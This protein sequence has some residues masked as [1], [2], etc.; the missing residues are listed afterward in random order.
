MYLVIPEMISLS[1]KTTL[2]VQ[3]FTGLFL[4]IYKDKPRI[5]AFLNGSF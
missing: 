3:D 2:I 4:L 1:G 5:T